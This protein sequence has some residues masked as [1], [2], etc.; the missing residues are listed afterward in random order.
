MDERNPQQ[1]RAGGDDQGHHLGLPGP[2]AP[3]ASVGSDDVLDLIRRADDHE[4][5]RPF[6]LRG[7]QDAVAATFGVHAFL[8]DAARDHLVASPRPS[9]EQA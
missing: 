1:G 8:V 2:E 9:D 3:G 4:L 6:L 5:G 7:A